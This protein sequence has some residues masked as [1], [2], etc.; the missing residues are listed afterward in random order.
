MNDKT[1]KTRRVRSSTQPPSDRAVDLTQPA[2]GSAQT[3][4]QR[5]RLP[6]ERDEGVGMTAPRPD[7]RIKQGLDDLARGVQDTSRAPEADR[8]YRQTKKR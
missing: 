2:P 3:G 6:H 1:P 7:Q 4:E 5:P 8:A